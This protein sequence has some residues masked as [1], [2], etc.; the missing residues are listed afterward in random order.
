MFPDNRPLHTRR[1][2]I[3]FGIGVATFLLF[4]ILLSLLG[5]TDAVFGRFVNPPVVWMA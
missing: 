4:Q 1:R 5:L 3:V 2:L